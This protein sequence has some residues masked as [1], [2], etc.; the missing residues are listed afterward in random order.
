MSAEHAHRNVSET[1]ALR[2]AVIESTAFNSAAWCKSIYPERFHKPFAPIHRSIF[3]A[4]D[5]DSIQKI[6]ITA[7]RGFG[8][9]SICH[10]GYPSREALIGRRRFIVPVSAT[11][12]QA[13]LQAENM[14]R[15]F[16]TNPM[17][18]SF[19][20]PQK[21]GTW[22]R[23]MWITQ[24]GCMIFPR[25]RGQQV[26]G[27]LFKDYRP[28]LLLVDDFEDTESVMSDEQ[29][30]KY[31]DWFFTD[32]MGSVDTGSDNWRIIVIG[33]LLH[34]DSLLAN[35]I[36]DETWH[37][38]DVPLADPNFKSNWP[39]KTSDAKV[40]EMVESYRRQGMIDSFYRE[41]MN[42]M[43]S[44]E[45]QPFQRE[46]FKYYEEADEKLSE[47]RD[48][49]NIVLVDP[50]KTLNPKSADTAI[51]G[52]AFSAEKNQ[53]YV[54]DV[55]AGKLQTN[56]VYDNTIAM[57]RRINARNIGAE[58][59]SL[60]MWITY[61]FKNELSRRAPELNFVE[62]NARGKKEERVR[63]L[64]PFYRQGLVYHNRAVTAKLEAQLLSFPRSK[65]WDV[66]DALA[67]VAPMLSEGERYMYKD[68]VETGYKVEDE[69][70]DV[71]I[72]DN[73][74]FALDEPCSTPSWFV[75]DSVYG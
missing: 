20:G 19:F 8:K 38:I 26:R 64:I 65:L 15:E 53:I 55:I 63:A 11:N 27:N 22:S 4:L 1:E 51:V 17:I 59:T 48:V 45:D 36:E 42:E 57:A 39:E 61:P 71:H 54:R 23:D 74:G 69:Y 21:T 58:V 35:L 47:R 40:V 56:E 2:A 72:E 9:T 31:K 66:M 62:L 37:H 60:N 5:D 28:D 29:R 3:D 33:T 6:V 32:L 44:T 41:Y 13:I 46:H 7:F 10:L 73:Y 16:M 75:G 24:S 30:R 50:A 70:K 12:S 67:Y 68:F 49:E 52:V 14:K 18:E 34:E 25:G 43:M